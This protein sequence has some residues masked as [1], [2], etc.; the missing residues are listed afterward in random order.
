[1]KNYKKNKIILVLIISVLVVIFIG[2]EEDNSIKCLERTD[3]A[4][5][6]ID[7]GGENCH[8]TPKIYGNIEN[9]NIYREKD[10]S[11]EEAI[12]AYNNI[13]TGYNYRKLEIKN[14]NTTKVN[15]IHITLQVT[16]VL[17]VAIKEL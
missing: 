3:T 14:I 7:C 11:N 17:A 2:C 13:I 9:V 12:I 16:D 1:M 10:V 5:D 6:D 8:C 15:A 4:I